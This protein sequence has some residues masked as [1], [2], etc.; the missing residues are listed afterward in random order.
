MSEGE[1]VKRIILGVVA[2]LAMLTLTPTV[3]SAAVSEPVAAS[4]RQVVVV[5]QQATIKWWT[6]PLAGASCSSP[7]GQRSFYDSRLHQWRS[8]MHWGR[9][10][11]K[12]YRAPVLAA[13]NG[14]VVQAG[15]RGDYGYAVEIRHGKPGTASERHTLYGHLDSINVHRGQW[16][17]MGTVIARL[18]STG[19]STGNHLH[20]EF[21][22]P[23]GTRVNP[24]S[25]MKTRGVAPL[26]R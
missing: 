5:A 14:T 10:L 9:D 15:W 12:Y 6:A 3:A 17:R 20:F 24:D 2:V 23:S 11:L 22:M 25:Y 19:D 1:P 16:V 18:G 4:S 13:A 26:C 8:G 21:R 7:F